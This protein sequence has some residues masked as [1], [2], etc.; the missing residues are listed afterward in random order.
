MSQSDPSFDRR[1]STTDS[2]LSSFQKTSRRKTMMNSL[3]SLKKSTEEVPELNSNFDNAHTILQE[4][5]LNDPVTHEAFLKWSIRENTHSYILLYDE[6]QNFIGTEDFEQRS[7]IGEAILVTYLLS[8][9]QFRTPLELPEGELDRIGVAMQGTEVPTTSFLN[10]HSA[11]MDVLV[12][13][14]SRF[15]ESYGPVHPNSGPK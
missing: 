6:I 10:V 12:A 14:N 2:D 11:L 8:R 15:M 1:S 4:N 5:T 9:A 3:F 13:M 7:H